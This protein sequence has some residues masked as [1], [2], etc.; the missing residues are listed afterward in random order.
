MPR[1]IISQGLAEL[2]YTVRVVEIRAPGTFATQAF[3]PAITKFHG[4]FAT[5]ARAPSPLKLEPIRHSQ[6]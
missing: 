5:D 6:F 1:G 2:W 4:P 3:S